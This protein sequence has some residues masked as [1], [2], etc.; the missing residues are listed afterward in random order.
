[1]DSSDGKAAEF[2]VRGAAAL[3][4]VLD[5]EQLAEARAAHDAVLELAVEGPYAR[6]VHDPWRKS[7]ALA[8]LAGH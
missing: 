5:D 7:P 3:G 2:A 1:M 6:I 8:E 4:R